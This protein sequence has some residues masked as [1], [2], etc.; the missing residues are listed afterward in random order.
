MVTF[1]VVMCV[2][3]MLTMFAFAANTTEPDAAQKIA[4]GISD[5]MKQLL[6]LIRGI[7]IPIAAIVLGTQGIMM[8]VG[9]QRAAENAKKTMLICIV[10]IAVVYFAPLAVETV[11]SWFSGLGS[12]NAFNVTLTTD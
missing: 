2:V 11:S 3:M 1:A 6:S 9:G 8:L 7:V 4:N 12:G 5:G 10:A